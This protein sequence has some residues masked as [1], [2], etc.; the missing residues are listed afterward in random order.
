MMI[1]LESDLLNGALVVNIYPVLTA[2]VSLLAMASTPSDSCDRDSSFI[3]SIRN[4]TYIFFD[5]L[6]LSLSLV[7]FSHT[8]VPS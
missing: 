8:I 3:H 4:E 6:S 5:Y 1:R 7:H 2:S